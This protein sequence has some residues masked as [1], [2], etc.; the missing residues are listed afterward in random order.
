MGMWIQ[1][2]DD[3]RKGIKNI[4]INKVAKWIVKVSEVSKMKFNQ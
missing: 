2:T 4:F 3:F 1:N